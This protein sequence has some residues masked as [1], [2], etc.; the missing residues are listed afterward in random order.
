MSIT[1]YGPGD[2]ATWGAP[3]GHP[4][5]PRS[6]EW[7]GVSNKLRILERAIRQMTEEG[8]EYDPLDPENMGEA[9]SQA[10]LERFVDLAVQGRWQI[11]VENLIDL[12]NEYWRAK[13]ENSLG[14]QK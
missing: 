7:S 9:L 13:A 4:N 14:R 5:D 6:D 8:G 1:S 11:A 2:S 12:S 10:N 3:T